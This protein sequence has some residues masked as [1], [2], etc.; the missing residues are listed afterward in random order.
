MNFDENDSFDLFVLGKKY[1][2][3]EVDFLHKRIYMG[4]K[5]NLF[6]SISPWT[7][8]GKL[9]DNS[10][11]GE[12]YSPKILITHSDPFHICLQSTNPVNLEYYKISY[13]DWCA[14]LDYCAHNKDEYK[15]DWIKEGF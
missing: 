6:E 4:I 12:D 14:F 2:C 15:I 3:H 11:Y 10:H 1:I 7:L 5:L 9:R 13:L 8:F